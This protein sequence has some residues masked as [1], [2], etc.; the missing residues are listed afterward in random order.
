MPDKNK[1]KKRGYNVLYVDD[2]RQNLVSFK[3]TFRKHYMIYAAQSGEEA[4]KILRKIKIDLIISDQRMP[5][6]TGVE[7]F[8]KIL[9]EFPNAVRMVLTGYSDVQSIIDAINKGQVYYYITKPWKH[10]ELKLIMDNALESYELKM[11]NKIL[12]SEKEELLLKTERQAKENLL[13]QYQMLKS[14]V[15]PHFLFNSLNALYALV[16]RDPKTAKQ[17]IVKLS[18]VYR[19]ALEYTDEMMI[20]LG[21]ELRFIRDYIFL[22]KIRFNENLIFKN[23]IPKKSHNTYIPPSTLQLLVENAIKHNIVSQESPLTIELYVS[24]GYLIVKNNFQLRKDDVVS[25]KIG[26]QNLI[27]RYSYIT[28]KKPIFEQKEGSYYAK[29]PLIEEE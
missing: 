13:S 18:K 7:L 8:E 28:S 3:A 29:V 26:Q 20:R 23:K 6:M 17:F 9:P 10:D 12:A 4:I 19:Y 27:A 15:N 21:D 25:T 1:R 22:Q 14:Q 16:D 24:E 2:E 11:Q 5:E